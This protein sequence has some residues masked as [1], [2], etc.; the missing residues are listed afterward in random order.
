MGESPTHI[1]KLGLQMDDNGQ[2]LINAFSFIVQLSMMGASCFL[3]FIYAVFGFYACDPD[4]DSSKDDPIIQYG[5]AALLIGLVI[6]VICPIYFN[7][8]EWWSVALLYLGGT[9]FF[10]FGVGILLAQIW[11]A[12]GFFLGSLGWAIVGHYISAVIW[13]NQDTV[14]LM[15][16]LVVLALCLASYFLGQ[17]FIAPSQQHSKPVVLGGGKKIAQW[18]GA[19]LTFLEFFNI[20]FGLFEK[21]L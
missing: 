7:A 5:P 15:K 14:F 9:L 1:D 10:C 11:D 2:F 3:G 21:I 13:P 18:I 6:G 17:S 16:I 19:I 20:I 4:Y 12:V 8:T